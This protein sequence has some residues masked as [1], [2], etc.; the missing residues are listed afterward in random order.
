MN[1]SSKH[2]LFWSPRVLCILFALFISIFAFDVFDETRSFWNTAIA[3]VIHLVP[4]IIIVVALIVS[5]KWEWIGGI[6]Y[7]VFALVYVASTWGRFPVF[8]YFIMSGPMVIISVLF[9]LN[10]KYKSELKTR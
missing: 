9:F 2:L 8:V 3:L 4:T 7:L 5:W 10:W 6:L 1:K